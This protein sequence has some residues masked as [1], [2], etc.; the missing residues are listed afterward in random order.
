MRTEASPPWVE[1]EPGVSEFA[2]SKTEMEESG[3]TH[4]YDVGMGTAG[5]GFEKAK[6]PDSEVRVE[7]PG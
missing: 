3:I 5:G 6:L 7:L 1:A 4:C 2:Y